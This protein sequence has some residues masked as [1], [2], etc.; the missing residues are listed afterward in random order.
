MIDQLQDTIRGVAR[1]IGEY[2]A[3]LEA[4]GMDEAEAWALTQ[5]LE[6]RMLGPVLDGAEAELQ[7]APWVDIE[8]L[9]V[10]AVQ[11]QLVLGQAPD[12]MAAVRYMRDAGVRIREITDDEAVQLAKRVPISATQIRIA[13][14]GCVE[15]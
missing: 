1:V 3:E 7:P 11:L 14:L 9:F 6:E 10:L 12:P 8:A 13:F 2:R 15:R 5:R 4:S